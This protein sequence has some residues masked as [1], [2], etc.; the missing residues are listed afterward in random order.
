MLLFSALAALYYYKERNRY[1]QEQKLKNRLVFSECTRLAKLLPS[2]K[3]CTMAPVEIDA[4]I[5]VIYKEIGAA[6]VAALLLIV[7]LGLLLARI[8]LKPL[9]DSVDAMDSFI[10]GIVHDINTPL[11]VIRMNAASLQKNLSDEKARS[12][13]SRVLQGVEHIE[14]LEEQLLFSLR[15]GQYTPR[16]DMFDLC[17]LLH[18]RRDYW[19][20]NRS[21]VDVRVSTEGSCG[22]RG[23]EKALLRMIDNVVGNAVKYSPS[24]SMVDVVFD[25]GMLSVSDRGPGIKNA[26]AVFRK[27]YRE[28]RKTTGVGLGLYIVA[29]IARMH[30]IALSVHSRPKEGTRFEM[31]CRSILAPSSHGTMAT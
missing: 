27:Y 25:N 21:R 19:A 15:I 1:F 4:K 24:K 12:K 14:A 23:D 6:F 10:N 8:S 13:N 28:S 11:S 29:E 18:E 3:E 26:K 16:M 30:G 20:S 22:V 9:R 7:P 2:A 5:M 31:D 17:A